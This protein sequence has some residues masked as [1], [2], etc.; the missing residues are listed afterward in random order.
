M[1]GHNGCHEPIEPLEGDPDGLCLECRRAD[2]FC[3]EICD[4]ETVHPD[5]LTEIARNLFEGDT[6]TLRV[7]AGCLTPGQG[8]EVTNFLGH[9]SLEGAG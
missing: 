2:P 1:L 7:C 5:E 3:C 4:Y 9:G 6:M 8:D